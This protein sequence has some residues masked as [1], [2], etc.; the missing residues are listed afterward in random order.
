M[1]LVLSL[2]SSFAQKTDMAKLQAL[3]NDIKEAG[4]QYPDFVMA[5]AL[6]ETGWLNCKRC[7]YRYHNLFGFYIR[8]N[9]CLKFA[10]DS[11]CIAYYKRWQERRLGKWMSKHPKG[12]YYDFLKHAE[13][14]T[15]D[16]YTG[17]LRPFVRWVQKKLK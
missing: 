9:K 16:K 15:G 12:T 2:Q 11:A 5:Q 13:Y 8:G 10:S 7:C 14:A 1:L 4:I 17:E 6:L 3:Y